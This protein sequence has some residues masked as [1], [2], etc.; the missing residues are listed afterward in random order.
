M[1]G[2]Q[3]DSMASGREGTYRLI[4]S[5]LKTNPAYLL[6]FS[7]GLLGGGM[8]VGTSAVGLIRHDPTSLTVGFGTWVLLLIATLLVIRFV[9]SRRRPGSGLLEGLDQKARD[10]YLAGSSADF[11]SGRWRAQWFEGH[12]ESRKP[13]SP[14]PTE[15]ISISTQGARVTCNSY[16]PSTKKTYWL[17]G[18]LSDRGVVSLIYWSQIEKG[19]AAL[20]GTVLMRVDDSFEGRGERLAGSWCGFTRDGK[21]TTGE[22]EWKKLG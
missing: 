4:V 17:D 3:A 21:I 10:A 19:I 13:Y 12:G 6:L 16:D 20:T 18:R 1:G 22:V 11:L 5:A 8:G 7:L 14:D 2:T 9:E 15:E